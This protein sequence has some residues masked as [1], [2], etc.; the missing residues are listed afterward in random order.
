MVEGVS[1]GYTEVDVDEEGDNED[2]GIE[3]IV[4]EPDEF[5][6]SSWDESVGD[7]FNEEELVDVSIHNEDDQDDSWEGNDDV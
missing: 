2:D 5:D 3:E 6:V 4:H 7:S 1:E